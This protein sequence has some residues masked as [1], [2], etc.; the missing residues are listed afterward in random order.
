MGILKGFA[1]TILSLLLFFSLIVFG[2]A[3]MVNST[4]LNPKFISS[5]IDRLDVSAV[6]KEAVTEQTDEED[7]P[8]ELMTAMVDTIDKLEAPVKQQVSAAIH[9]TYD[10][11]L[12]KK[13]RPD[14]MAT[15]GNTFFTPDFVASLMAELDLAE[16]AEEVISQQAFEGGFTEDAGN[17]LVSTVAELEPTIK[18]KVP[19]A[20]APVFDY[21][22]GKTEN[23]NLALTLRAH[24]L[25]S[26]FVASL[27]DKL[28][29]VALLSE[30][31][32]EQLDEQLP[33]ELQ[34]LSEYV[35]NAIAE[36]EPTIKEEIIASAD[37]VLDYLL[38]IRQSVSVTISLDSVLESLENSLREAFLELP[39][40]EYSG[41][42]RGELNNL[43]DV[44]FAELPSD[45]L[46][47]I[48]LTEDFFPP[49]LPALIAGALAEIEQGLGEARQSIANAV[50]E[51]EAKLEE[52]REYIR[53]FQ[54]YYYILI[55]WLVILVLAIILINH[56]V[57]G[58]S[59]W[60]GVTFFIYGA[61]FA[62][63]LFIGLGILETQ[64]AESAVETG[65]PISLQTWIQQLPGQILS[66]LQML[67]IGLAVLGV[68]LIVVS[69]VY[70]R[71]RHTSP[72]D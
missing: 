43:F 26:D 32:G 69:F 41:L 38:G 29:V 36:L 47:T 57:K 51:A 14:L 19:P 44:Y 52:A 16:L 48:E 12:G 63:G 4:A 56:E 50:A 6:I 68:V 66:P 22:L 34:Y 7:F 10:Y 45:M 20:S 3:Y 49:E 46:P 65:L 60:L 62:T 37:P 55:G 40:P 67:S 13:A 17:A 11:L 23:I 5:Q 8:E 70:P 28:D 25:T 53:Q 61:I 64:I 59:R 39:P 72:L 58:A 33:E 54:M 27:I 30:F 71:L 42:S 2:L 31:L 15:L 9:E 24:I 1:L 35:D 21:L 18:Q